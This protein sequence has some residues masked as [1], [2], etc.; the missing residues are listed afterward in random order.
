MKMERSRI[1][2]AIS[3][4]VLNVFCGAGC[5]SSP[6]AAPLE[7]PQAAVTPPAQ[8]AAAPG[9]EKPPAEPPK[10]RDA[11]SYT[12]DGFKLG[13]LYGSE[14]MSRPPYDQP[15]DND[16][17][18]NKARRFMVYGARPCRERT[19]PENTTVLFYIKYTDTRD[20]YNQP[21]EAFGW[22]G[23]NYFASRSDFPV[24]TGQP[25]S[26]VNEALG[27]PLK[28]FSVERKKARVT[29]Q[30]HPGDVWSVVEDGIAV[31]FVVGPM[32]QDPE[33]EQWRGL[34]QMFERYTKAP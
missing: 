1:H 14:V 19:F 2:F 24:R 13:T 3:A 10:A 31:G 32:P 9:G 28:T 25:S 21:I 4:I 29:V 12:F 17:I 18:D 26:A 20:D 33:S 16:P 7:V 15:C 34:M 8:P 6:D 22:L 5:G 30:Q 23:G 11:A 27:A